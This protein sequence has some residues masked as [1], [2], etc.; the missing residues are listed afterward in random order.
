MTDND[1]IQSPRIAALRQELE[2]GN[3]P[4][5][6]AFWREVAEKDAPLFEPVEGNEQQMLVTFLWRG[7]EETRNVVV[8]GGLAI[9]QPRKY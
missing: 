6:D 7:D 9:I 2:A 5:L 4:A 1:I 3:S 8:I